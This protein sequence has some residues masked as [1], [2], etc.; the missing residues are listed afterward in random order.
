MSGN[1]NLASNAKATDDIVA[2]ANILLPQSTDATTVPSQ[3]RPD[4]RSTHLRQGQPE[5]NS[6]DQRKAFCHQ[7]QS[8]ISASDDIGQENEV[9]TSVDVL[10]SFEMYNTLHGNIPQGNFDSYVHEYPPFYDEC[11]TNCDSLPIRHEQSSLENQSVSMASSTPFRNSESFDLTSTTNSY[12]SRPVSSPDQEATRSVPIDKLYTLPRIPTPLTIDIHITSKAPKFNVASQRES[13]LREF[14]SGEI[15]HGYCIVENQSSQPIKFEMFYLT[16][17][18]Y[19]STICK[20]NGEIKKTTKR[21]LRMVDLSASWSYV[22]EDMTTGDS[23][24]GIVDSIDGTTFGLSNARILYPR[25]RCKK[26]FNF[27]IPAQ[28][29]DITCKNEHFSHCLLPPSL[30]IDRYTNRDKNSNIRVD[31]LLGYGRLDTEGSPL[32]TEDM[33]GSTSINYAVNGTIVGRKG[34]KFHIMSEN[35]HHLRVIPFSFNSSPIGGSYSFEQFKYSK[36]SIMERLTVLDNVFAKLK[37]N[38]SILNCDIN[39]GSLPENSCTDPD[40]KYKFEQPHPEAK[41][42]KEE[43][44]KINDTVQVQT[45]YMT[46][47]NKNLKFASGMFDGF[48]KFASF[49]SQ[50][51][52]SSIS[53]TDISGMISIKGKIPNLALTYQSPR[54]IKKQNSFDSKIEGD[55]DNWLRLNKLIPKEEKEMLTKLHIEF[56]CL[57]SNNSSPHDPPALQSVKTELIC[58]TTKSDDCIPIEMSKNVYELHEIKETYETLLGEIEE[59]REQFDENFVH[60]NEVYN[61]N[62]DILEY[63]ELNFTDFVSSKMFAFVK[64]LASLDVEE[65][66]LHDAFKQKHLSKIQNTPHSNSIAYNPKSGKASGASSK[67]HHAYDWIKVGSLEYK[68]QLVLDLEFRD[69]MKETL[70]PSFQS[71]L[72]TRSYFVRVSMK[73]DT[74]MGIVDIDI[75][76]L[77]KNSYID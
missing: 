45:T 56:S 14:T 40:A 26:F 3:I 27:K 49:Q 59:Y 46:K 41:T 4:A 39:T 44:S 8:L 53:K 76:I 16:F 1:S 6:K 43:Q 15:V 35:R 72:C 48:R 58:V 24:C 50:P 32:L 63:R 20:E 5:H 54:L 52:H 34:E 13:V 29:L 66:H 51:T 62:R 11:S 69:S 70:V 74:N 47:S 21:F 42:L 67:E 23:V 10:P 71:C 75:P 61:K 12:R 18:G 28:L 38:S 64:S 68:S 25:R 19:I 2:S 30:G 7:N 9:E 57:Q 22:E 55:K 36:Q 37:M 17:E 31:H 77:I 73:F 60:L 65:V 33:S